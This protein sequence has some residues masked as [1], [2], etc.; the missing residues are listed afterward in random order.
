[1]ALLLGSLRGSLSSVFIPAGRLGTSPPGA[2]L[3][4]RRRT[5][6]MAAILGVGVVRLLRGIALIVS[7]SIK[8]IFS[9]NSHVNSTA[10]L[11]VSAFQN[12]SSVSIDSS[13]SPSLHFFCGSWFSFPCFPARSKVRGRTGGDRNHF[14]TVTV[15]GFSFSR[16]PGQEIGTPTILSSTDFFGTAVQ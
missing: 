7:S 9:P 3:K 8:P 1:M 2:A 15:H 14:A 5:Y 11:V 4:A 13:T 16:G 12:S 10:S 6:E